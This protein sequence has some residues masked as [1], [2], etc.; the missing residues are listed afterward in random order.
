MQTDPAQQYS[1][2]FCEREYNARAA[3]P[4]HKD[5]FLRWA[6]RSA[7]ARSAM[8]GYLDLPYGPGALQTLDLFPADTARGLM[9]LIHGGYWRSLDKSDFSFVAEPFIARGISVASINYSLCPAARIATI[10]DDAARAIAWLHS[11]A[12]RFGYAGKPIVIAGHSAGGHL[13]AMMLTRDWPA[14]GVPDP[15]IAGAIGVSGIYDLEPLLHTSMNDDLHLDAA[16]LATVSPVR[17]TPTLRVPLHL[18]A[19]GAESGEFQRQGRVLAQAWPDT[20]RTCTLAP[21][22][23]HFSIVEHFADAQSPAFHAAAMLFA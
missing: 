21:G 6:A 5:F 20:V 3:V 11:H 1:R 13:A 14:Y 7:A 16:A 8:S 22:E 19:G 2:N 12:S 9:V 4:T 10:V 23:N 17:L 15:A 18:V